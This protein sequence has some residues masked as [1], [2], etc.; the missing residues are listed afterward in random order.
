M[1]IEVLLY[2]TSDG[3]C[4]FEEWFEELDPDAAARVNTAIAR[5]AAGN[6]GDSKSLG[7]GLWERRLDFDGGYRLY[8]VR[9]GRALVVLLVG[10]TKRRQKANIAEAYKLL[11][12][13]QTRKKQR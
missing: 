3:H 13:Y 9:D 2:V 4:P 8:F 11:S 12:D 1:E 6:F 7:K 10:G 5:M